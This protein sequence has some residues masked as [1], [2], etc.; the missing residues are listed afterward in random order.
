[1]VVNYNQAEAAIPAVRQWFELY[2]YKASY[3][4]SKK[5]ADFAVAVRVQS[6]L[7][8]EDWEKF[9]QRYCDI[10]IDVRYL[11]VVSD[12]GEEDDTKTLRVLLMWA[13]AGLILLTT[14]ALIGVLLGQ[15]LGGHL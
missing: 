1:M 13:G 9:P 11:R 7:T 2:G 15:L 8:P 4:V 14:V 6:N 5:G 10:P 12:L 3:G